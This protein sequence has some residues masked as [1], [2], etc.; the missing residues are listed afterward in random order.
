[1]KGEKD[2]GREGWRDEGCRKGGRGEPRGMEGWMEVREGG[3]DR[4]REEWT[5][6]GME[7][8]KEGKRREGRRDG[9]RD[10]RKRE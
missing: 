6:G 10:D 7:G 4:G 1:M 8:I 5:D 3:M 9:K 2:E